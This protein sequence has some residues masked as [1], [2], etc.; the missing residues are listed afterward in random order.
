MEKY[1]RP[2]LMDTTSPL[3]AKSIE[4]AHA[5]LHVRERGGPNRGPEVERFLRRVHCGPGDPWCAAFVS[6]V[7]S[8]AEQQVGGPGQ[9]MTSASALKLLLL[10]PG[11]RLSMPEPGC[12]FV[13]DHGN[14]KGHCGFVVEVLPDGHLVTIE[15]NTGPGPAA[16]AEDRDGQGVY[17][18]QDRRVTDCYGFL[19]IA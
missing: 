6:D 15:G 2:R 8:E 19:R 16:P 18:R 9:F 12:V 11:L 3:A 17:M 14:G 4:I 1:I 7:I 13:I 10:N 5:L